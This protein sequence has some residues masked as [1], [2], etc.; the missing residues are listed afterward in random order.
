[1]TLN[2]RASEDTGDAT[3]DEIE[4][5][6]GAVK[7]GELSET[8]DDDA[9]KLIFK[10]DVLDEVRNGLGLLRTKRLPHANKLIINDINWL[11]DGIEQSGTNR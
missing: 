8:S 3:L 7:L 11:L 5:I 9:V 6:I 4:Q 2:S 10:P 1:M